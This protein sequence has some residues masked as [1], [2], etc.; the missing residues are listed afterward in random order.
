MRSEVIE[1]WI[2]KTVHTDLLPV[3]L[4]FYN[5]SRYFVLKSSSISIINGGAY[6]TRSYN[7][8]YFF[9]FSNHNLEFC[10]IRKINYRDVI[11][12]Y[13]SSAKRKIRIDHRHA[14]MLV[15]DI[16]GGDYK[17]LGLPGDLIASSFGKVCPKRDSG[18]LIF[19]YLY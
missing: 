11:Q 1:S 3:I 8:V 19:Y 15:R 14:D 2:L 5:I 12:H 10:F 17:S 18:T 13:K 7:T 16:Y 6:S 4:P 9:F